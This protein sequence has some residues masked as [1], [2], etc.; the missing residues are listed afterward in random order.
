MVETEKQNT[1]ANVDFLTRL[2]TQRTKQR[3][4]KNNQ[5]GVYK[6]YANVS[7]LITNTN[8]VII[9]CHY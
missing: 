2:D 6:R 8:R 9:S 3:S 7:T 4:W 1:F 5:Q